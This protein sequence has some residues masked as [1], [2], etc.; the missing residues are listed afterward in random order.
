MI[1]ENNKVDV[2]DT[3]DAISVSEDCEEMGGEN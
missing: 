1:N 2:V 3:D